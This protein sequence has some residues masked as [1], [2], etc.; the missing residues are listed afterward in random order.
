MLVQTL[1][2]VEKQGL[3]LRHV[4]TVVP[5]K[6]EYEL[7]PLGKVFAEAVEMLYRWGEAHPEALNELAANNASN[8]M[9]AGPDDQHL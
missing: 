6:V 3:V 5:P 1:R 2:D 8:E 9:E 7:T 4:R